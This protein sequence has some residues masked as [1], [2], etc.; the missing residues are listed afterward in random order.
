MD[1][2][3]DKYEKAS[4]KRI[5]RD[6]TSMVFSKNVSDELQEEIL[7]GAELPTI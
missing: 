3:L 7:E 4:R 6:K 1:Q 2:L 5:K